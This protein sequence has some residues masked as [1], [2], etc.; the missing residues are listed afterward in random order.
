MPKDT[1]KDC[2]G[3]RYEASNQGE[4]KNLATHLMVDKRGEE[5]REIGITFSTADK[6]DESKRAEMVEKV[7]RQTP[8][9]TKLK[10]DFSGWLYKP[11]NCLG[12]KLLETMC[13][14]VALED[15]IQSGGRSREI[16]ASIDNGLVLVPASEETEAMHADN[17]LQLP[18]ASS[19]HPEPP[20]LPTTSE[21]AL[22][23]A[24][25]QSITV[26]TFRTPTS[27]CL[28]RKAPTRL[29]CFVHTKPRC[30]RPFVPPRS[31]CMSHS[32]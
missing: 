18:Q 11:S 2:G 8:N 21:E 7:L 13:K 6:K 17:I 1:G 15:I 31:L 26:N 3:T 4:L 32:P 30:S 25:P 5:A 12:D 14:L 9:L 16:A 20:V 22:G 19:S 24:S 23:S 10:L 29:Q 28:G 27:H